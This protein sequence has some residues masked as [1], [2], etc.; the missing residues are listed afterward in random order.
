MYFT[1]AKWSNSM[2]SQWQKPRSL[3]I[4]FILIERLSNTHCICKKNQ[5]A[6]T[7]LEV[8]NTINK[9]VVIFQSCSSIMKENQG[10]KL[11]L[12]SEK[13]TYSWLIEASVLNKNIFNVPFNFSC[14]R[15]KLFDRKRFGN[16]D[17]TKSYK[18]THFPS[19]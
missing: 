17:C 16:Y 14:N 2:L 3:F 4:Y 9:H 7:P 5:K 11:S 6:P 8:S 10:E 18:V 15:Q 1:F 19:K 12:V 13:V